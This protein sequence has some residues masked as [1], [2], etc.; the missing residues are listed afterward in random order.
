M[1]VKAYWQLFPLLNQGQFAFLTFHLDEVKATNHALRR[2]RDQCH[3]PPRRLPSRQYLHQSRRRFFPPP[4]P[5]SLSFESVTTYASRW[6]SRCSHPS[7]HSPC[8]LHTMW[9]PCCLLHPP[10]H[11]RP[12]RLAAPLPTVGLQRPPR[13]PFHL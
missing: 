8:R 12:R 13:N 4:P 3:R 1:S 6:C 11:R 7:L 10:L 5:H 2:T 9:C